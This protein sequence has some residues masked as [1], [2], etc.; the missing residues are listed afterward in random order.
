[1]G[2]INTDSFF[3]HS[4]VGAFMSGNA[5]LS[6]LNDGIYGSIE[7]Y[8]GRW[9]SFTDSVVEIYADLHELKNIHSV[10]MR[11]MEDQVGSAYLPGSVDIYISNDNKQYRKA[12]TL[13]NEKVPASL[14]RHVKVMKTGLLNGRCR[15]IKVVLYKAALSADAAKHSMLLDEIT[16][17]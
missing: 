1:M 11:F 6:K 7:A 2:A 3:I 14:L 17:D 13:V 4:L 16:V 15:Y 5:A 10:T 8:D 12:K 9:V